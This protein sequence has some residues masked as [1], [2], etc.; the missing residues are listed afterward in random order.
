MFGCLFRL[1]EVESG[2]ISIDGFSIS[3]VQILFRL[4]VSCAEQGTYTGVLFTHLQ[5]LVVPQHNMQHA[6]SPE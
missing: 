4:F 6:D 3:K 1:I 2:A 5:V